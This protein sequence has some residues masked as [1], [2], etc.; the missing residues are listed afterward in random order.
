ME[1]S[2]NFREGRIVNLAPSQVVNLVGAKVI[3]IVGYQ[4]SLQVVDDILTAQVRIGERLL[5]V[6]INTVPNSRADY[7]NIWLNPMCKHKAYRYG[8]YSLIKYVTLYQ[9]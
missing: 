9:H 2:D 3:T 7:V 8:R 1:G 6:I 4:N 5:G